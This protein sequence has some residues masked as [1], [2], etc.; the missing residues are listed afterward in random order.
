MGDDHLLIF[1]NIVKPVYGRPSFIHI[2]QY[3]ETSVWE[4]IIYSYFII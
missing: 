4:T 3:Y 2:V 1:F